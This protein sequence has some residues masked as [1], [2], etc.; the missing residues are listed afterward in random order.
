VLIFIVSKLLKVGQECLCPQ[1]ELNYCVILCIE[2]FLFYVFVTRSVLNE[3]GLL[4]LLSLFY[5]FNRPIHLKG[6]SWLH[7]ASVIFNTLISNWC[8]QR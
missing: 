6:T 5:T 1:I 7:R 8:T 4:S 2:C 3:A